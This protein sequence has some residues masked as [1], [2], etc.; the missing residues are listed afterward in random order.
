MYFE[1]TDCFVVRAPIERTWEFFASAANLERITPPWLKFRVREAGP[2][3][4]ENG[5]LLNYT[6]SWMGLPIRWRTKIIEWSPPSRFIDLQVRGPYALWLHTH[7]FTPTDEGTLCTDRVIY[8]VPLPG[9]GRLVHRAFVCKQLLEIFRFRREV[10]GAEL[11]WV[12]AEQAD[13]RIGAL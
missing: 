8:R 7:T 10:I 1:L 4:I 9:V 12:R 11:G 6:I 13:V 3:T 2:V 5:T